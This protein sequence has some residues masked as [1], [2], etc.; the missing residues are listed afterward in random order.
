MNTR[1]RILLAAAVTV[2]VLGAAWLWWSQSRPTPPAEPVPVAVPV[3]PPPTPMASAA[4]APEPPP[5]EVPAPAAPLAAS[6][7]DK[8]LTELIGRK[9][10]LSFLQLD[11]F[12]RRFVAT[13]DNLGRAQAPAAVWP[14]TPMAGRF[15][16]VE[17]DTGPVISPDNGQR[18][19]AFVL[20][21]ESVDTARAVDLYLRMYPL[22]QQ[23]YV[24]LGYPRQQFNDRLMAVTR[25]LLATPDAA[26]PQ[27]LVLTEVKGPIE[28][29]RPWVRY[30]FADPALESLA[31][32]QKILLRVGPVNERRLKARLAAF[33][34]EL[35]RRLEKR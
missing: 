6:D 26:Q 8:A 32:G 34:A 22:L 17:H 33:R 13:V 27:K 21:A 23:A 18:Y 10:V 3:A 1:L 19:T 15:T 29:L 9:G 24:D 5:V 16:V 25:L 20:L 31:A 12:A 28:S 35:A 7:I 14:V 4:P 11:G 2:A 30:Q